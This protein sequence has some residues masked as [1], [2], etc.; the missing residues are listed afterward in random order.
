ME[1]RSGDDP[2]HSRAGLASRDIELPGGM[3]G[4]GSAEP[5]EELATPTTTVEATGR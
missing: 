1:P 3:Q 5:T 2:G 4:L